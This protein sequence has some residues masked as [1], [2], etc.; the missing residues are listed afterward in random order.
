M[1]YTLHSLQRHHTWQL[2][3][4]ADCCAACGMDALVLFRRA[5]SLWPHMHA[6]CSVC[7]R[8][9][10]PPAA[11]AEQMQQRNVVCAEPRSRQ[12]ADCHVCC[13]SHSPAHWHISAHNLGLFGHRLASGDTLNNKLAVHVMVGKALYNA[14]VHELCCVLVQFWLFPAGHV[15]GFELRASCSTTLDLPCGCAFA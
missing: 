2:S 8:L 11:H 5:S 4:T 9:L 13:C 14:Q 10:Q 15:C 6:S 1:I 12:Q 7:N 3:P